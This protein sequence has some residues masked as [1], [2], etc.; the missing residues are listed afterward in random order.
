MER[1]G[2]RC[3]SRLA[4][5]PECYLKSA[6]AKKNPRSIASGLVNRRESMNDLL[7]CTEPGCVRYKDLGSTP[8]ASAERHWP[9]DSKWTKKGSGPIRFARLQN[10]VN[11]PVQGHEAIAYDNLT[12]YP[13]LVFALA[14]F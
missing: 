12:G 5:E 4:N 14:F 8:R 1:G 2:R 7:G 11:W 10:A 3:S 6:T 13:L 9:C